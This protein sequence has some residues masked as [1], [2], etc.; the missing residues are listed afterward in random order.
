[1]NDHEKT[2]VEFGRSVL[3]LRCLSER[4]SVRVDAAR[5]VVGAGILLMAGIVTITSLMSGTYPIPAIQVV[6]T[7]L[8]TEDET[9][10]MIVVEWRL[11]RVALAFLLGSCLGMSGAIFQSLTRNPLGSPDIIGFSAGSYT[12]AL[13]VILLFSGGYY[14]TAAGALVGGIATASLVYLLAWRQGV[15]GCRLIIVGIGVAA[16]LGAF[17]A[18]MIREA[19]LQVAMSAAIWGAGSLNGLGVEQLIPVMLAVAILVPATLLFSRPLRQLEMGD[20]MARASGVD[21]N[22]SRLVLMVLG[23]ALT[24]IVTAA[25]GPISFIALVAPQIARRLTRSAGPTLGTSGL[26][27]GLLLLIADWAAQHALGV[28]LPVGVMTVSIGGLYFLFLLL[29]EGR[30]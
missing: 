10:R 27:G 6:R 1:M 13:I 29:R 15:Q 21:A 12:G 14:E 24:A 9:L 3:R 7:L 17:N 26:A 18:W 22:R 19:D 25:A 2:V 8:D 16:M 28:Q 30:K 11:P 20:D 4:L 23:V 5:L